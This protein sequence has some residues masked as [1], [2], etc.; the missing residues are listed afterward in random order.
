MEI[1]RTKKIEII[2]PCQVSI[3]NTT[4]TSSTTTTTTTTNN[5]DNNMMMIMVITAG[6]SKNKRVFI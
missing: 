5:N 2:I 6:V 4:T 3:D 1:R